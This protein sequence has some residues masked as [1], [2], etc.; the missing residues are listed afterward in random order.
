MTNTDYRRGQL[1]AAKARHRQRQRVAGLVDLCLMGTG[2]TARAIQA[3]ACE[4]DCTRSEAVSRA[5]MMGLSVVF[6][7]G[8]E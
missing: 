6:R 8:E 1:R 4:W 7:E 5:V 3:L 2:D